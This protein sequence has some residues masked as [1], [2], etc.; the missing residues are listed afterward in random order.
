MNE[1]DL[2]NFIK[3][4]FEDIEDIEV[5]YKIV[6]MNNGKIKIQYKHKNYNFLCETIF[7]KNF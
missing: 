7:K 6:F 1:E 3:E 2:I 5:I 4:I